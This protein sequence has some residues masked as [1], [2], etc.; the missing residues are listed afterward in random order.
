LW[1]QLDRAIKRCDGG[2]YTVELRSGRKLEYFNVSNRGGAC[3]AQVNLGGLRTTMY[4]GLLTEYVGQATDRDVFAEAMLRLIDNGFRVLWT[5]H[6][7]AICE[8]PEDSGLTA[9]DM[10][11]IMCVT[12]DWAEGLPVDAEVE[13]VPHYKK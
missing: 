12:P 9:E 6:D 4:G 1:D 7:E 8:V 5:V 3:T 13:E 10:R 2:K 11:R